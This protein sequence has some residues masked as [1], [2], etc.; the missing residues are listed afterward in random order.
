MDP[1]PAIA[2]RAEGSLRSDQV[3][4][5]RGCHDVPK[6]PVINLTVLVKQNAVTDLR[7]G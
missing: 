3:V 5:L 4:D 6:Y 2:K 1:D 7:L